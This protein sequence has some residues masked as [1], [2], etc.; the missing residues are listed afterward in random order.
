M[1]EMADR[2]R[3]IL[4]VGQNVRHIAAS[5]SRAG[6]HVFA[7]DCY[8]DLDLVE[9]ATR[10]LLLDADP[11]IPGDL[12]RSARLMIRDV[13][14]MDQ[15]DGLVLGPG[16]EDMRVEGLRVLNNPPDK[17]ST[18]SDKLWLA[19]W[20]DEEGFATL[21]TRPLAEAGDLQGFP[22]M[23]KPRRGAGGFE[24]R[25]I[26]TGEELAGVG[27]DL[28]VQEMVEGTPA[29]VSVVA[30]GEEAVA[31]S[32]NEQLI[33]TYWLGGTGFRYCG[34]IT[35]L[36]RPRYDG[37]IEEMM[38]IGEEIAEA[39][40]LV[41]SNG[42]DFILAESGPLV[43]EVNPRF[44]GSLDSVEIS[45]GMNLFQ[46]HLLSF[47]GV[48]PERPKPRGFGARG[49]LFADG[50]LGICADLRSVTPWV[51]DVPRPGSMAKRGDPVVSILSY[52]KEKSKAVDLLKGRS[53]RIL[54]ACRRLR[55]ASPGDY[56]V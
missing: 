30:D 25:Q 2:P 37:V 36:D 6:H 41:G 55:P 26:F 28:I 48:L 11:S 33:G 52:G 18:V 47:E 53:W 19:S 8:N 10:S 22:L 46:A 20:L 12:E 43:L 42:I 38:D 4:V 17:T 7:A 1:K 35:P 9:A 56:P 14:E 15:I 50:N 29:S 21:P 31:V 27:G 40:R 34:N 23:V 45:T 39:L 44:Q 49:I 3:R 51:A 16:I 54:R 13:V 24:N 5:A 32:A